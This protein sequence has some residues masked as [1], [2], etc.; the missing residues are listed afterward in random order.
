MGVLIT[1]ISL[2]HGGNGGNVISEVF[3]QQNTVDYTTLRERH[4]EEEFVSGGMVLSAGNGASGNLTEDIWIVANEIS[5]PAPGINLVAG[6]TQPQFQF[7]PSVGNTIRSV[8]LWCNM[9]TE[10][11]GAL[12]F[13]YPGIKGINLAG[14]WGLASGNR[15]ENIEVYKNG[16]AGIEN[17]VSVF[18]NAGESAKDNLVDY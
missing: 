7:P 6:W 13:M 11:P 12:E 5:S 16:V 9:I 1:A 10:H 18:H 2:E 4:D 8:H 3:I 15:V 14:G 17:D